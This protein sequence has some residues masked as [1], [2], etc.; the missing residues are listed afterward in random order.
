MRAGLFAI[1]ML[2]LPVGQGW[3]ADSSRGGSKTIFGPPLVKACALAYAHFEGELSQ[4]E[5][6][7]DFQFFGADIENYQITLHTEEN[8]LVVE[9]SLRPYQGSLVRGGSRKYEIDLRGQR[10]LNVER[11]R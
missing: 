9:F 5:S 7:T 1:A 2:V 3:T 10:I 4:R 6:T 8:E 11:Y